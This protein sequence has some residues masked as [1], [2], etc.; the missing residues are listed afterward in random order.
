MKYTANMVI[1]ECT[2]CHMI[3]GVTQKSYDRLKETGEGFSCPNGH[4]NYL[5]NTI[6][7]ELEQKK[8]EIT[9]K[10]KVIKE[11]EEHIAELMDEINQYK[12]SGK[13]GICSVFP[14]ELAF[15]LYDQGIKFLEDLI[16]LTLDDV[17][18]MD[19][20]GPQRCREFQQALEAGYKKF[21]YHFF[22]KNP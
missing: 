13:T 21:Y 3:F 9:G 19:G 15:R 17:K 22:G 1:L 10:E 18:R 7:D 16:H 14:E 11:K 4:K 8:R 5:K 6:K 20:I 12:W 2:T